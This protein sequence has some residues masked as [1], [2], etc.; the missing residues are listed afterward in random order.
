VTVPPIPLGGSSHPPLRG[1]KVSSQLPYQLAQTDIP[2]IVAAAAQG[3]QRAWHEL[4]KRY[5]DMLWRVTRAH[6]L[7]TVDGADVVQTSWLRLIEHL[8]Q[9]RNPDAL[10]AWLATTARR[11]CLRALRRAARCQPSEEV[12]PCATAALDE[13][14]AAL[15]TAERDDQLWAAFRRLP[16][17]DQ[18]L[19]RLLSADP[20]PSYGVISAALSMPVGSIG[21]TRARA[22]SR[23]RRELERTERSTAPHG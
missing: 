3:D 13:V 14:D 1:R 23:L 16:V 6:R 11:E 22:L 4:V 9:V 10:G 15:L 2:W 19:L 8:P 17:R 5:S 20:A 21:P 18:A 7:S 12:E